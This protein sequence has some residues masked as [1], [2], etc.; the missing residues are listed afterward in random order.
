[1]DSSTDQSEPKP[2]S[3]IVLT[4]LVVAIVISAGL[5][6]YVVYLN[7][8]S[9]ET[10]TPLTIKIGDQVELN[11]TG[12]FPYPD[13]RIFDTSV[14]S[15]A[16]NDVLYPKSLTF[17]KRT[18]D[19]YKELS[20]AAGNYGAGGTIKGFAMGVIGM[21]VGD[22][23]FIY[24][25]PEDAYPANPNMIE[26]HPLDQEVL[27]TELM[28]ESEF[29]ARYS[30]SPVIL[31]VFP[32]YFWGWNVT[33]TDVSAGVVTLKHQPTIGQTVYPFGNPFSESNP[34]GWR[35]V[36]ESYD[37][38]ANNGA[39]TVTVTH[40]LSEGDVYRVKGT[41]SDG[42][43]FIVTGFDAANETFEIHMNDSDTG[44]N[45][46]IVGRAL[47]FEVWIVSVVEG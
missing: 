11:Y 25:N 26:T 47:V 44:Y 14:L 19:T 2:R 10:I 21:K 17:S 20:M 24:I 43:T 29:S 8:T 30:R 34:S 15:V 36:V 13:G 4:L 1:M 37:P 46:E 22:H 12:R 38:A 35:V 27:G 5:V 18:N 41:G 31:S 16:W 33:I 23:K 6:V 9:P 42:T 28:S 32:H 7:R 39:G 3:R 40:V 45:A